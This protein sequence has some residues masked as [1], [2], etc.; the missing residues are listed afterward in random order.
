MEINENIL[1]IA[2]IVIALVLII[3]IFNLIVSRRIL[4]RFSG[5]L[6]KIVSIFEIESESLVQKYKST[7]FNNNFS[8]VKVQ[9]I[10]YIYNNQEFSFF[11]EIKK[12]RNIKDTDYIVVEDNI[13]LEQSYEDI[14]KMILGI[15]N[16]KSKVKKLRAFMTDSEGNV[17]KKSARQLRKNV[18]RRFKE[19]LKNEK[20]ERRNNGVTA[21]DDFKESM[22]KKFGSKKDKPK[23]AKVVPK[24][25]EKT[26]KKES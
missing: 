17:T 5:K 20:E 4:K 11:N 16:D 21:F 13:S 23:T 1:L 7:F 10:G 24:K 9:N 26:E 18:V 14:K 2:V 12:K 22:S 6:I 8:D 3:S 19:E 15:F 25:E